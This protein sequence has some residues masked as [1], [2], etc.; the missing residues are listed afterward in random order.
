MKSKNIMGKV[1]LLLCLGAFLTLAPAALAQSGSISGNP[2]PC[3]VYHT[4]T[5]CTST[6]SWSSAGTS[7]VQVWVS[8][9]GGAE[10]NFSTSGSGSGYFQDASWIQGMSYTYVFRLYDYSSGSRGAQ[11]ASASVSAVTSISC[12]P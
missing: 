3:T 7:Q 10:S 12:P 8:L 2:N 9:N 1:S 5:L 6:L 11:L 4:Q